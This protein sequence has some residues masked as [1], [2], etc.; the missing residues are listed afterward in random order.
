M[1]TFFVDLWSLLTKNADG[2]NS[3]TK[4][5]QTV[6]NITA[7]WIMIHLT[8]SGL[9]SAEY[10]LIYMGAL[11]A[12]RGFQTYLFNKTAI[13]TQDRIAMQQ[14]HHEDEDEDEPPTKPPRTG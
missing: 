12:A 5:W 10:L 2:T 13:K 3:S 6:A 14:Q 11:T 1:K 7:T 4:F 8:V 9:M